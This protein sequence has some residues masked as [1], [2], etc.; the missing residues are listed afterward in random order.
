MQSKKSMISH[1]LKNA[2]TEKNR[3]YLIVGVCNT[4]IGYFSG[5]YLYFLFK[6]NLRIVFISIISSVLSITISYLTYKIFVFKTRGNWIREYIKCYMVYGGISI[7]NIFMIWLFVDV[8]KVNIWL[9][10]GSSTLIVTVLSYLGHNFFTF[11]T[12]NEKIN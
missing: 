6:D 12:H 4:L 1:K 11:K 8:L 2:L 10:L 3:R 9:S 7:L 5:I